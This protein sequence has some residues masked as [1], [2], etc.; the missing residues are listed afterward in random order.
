[1]SKPKCK[2]GGFCYWSPP[3]ARPYFEKPKKR[4]VRFTRYQRMLLPDGFV[5]WH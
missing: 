3:D 4:K 5:A 2:C 1:M